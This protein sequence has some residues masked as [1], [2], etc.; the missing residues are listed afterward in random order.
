MC[1]YIHV[2]LLT[3]V[4]KWHTLVFLITYF[5]LDTPTE[6]SSIKHIMRF[7]SAEA[8]TK[9]PQQKRK[10]RALRQLGEAVGLLKEDRFE[11]A[12]QILFDLRSHS[13]FRRRG[14]IYYILG[15]TLFKM[16]LFQISAFQFSEVIRRKDP[17]YLQPSVEKLI[18]LTNEILSSSAVLN[19]AL[20]N[21]DLASFP[22]A[23]R[24]RLHLRI[25]EV[26]VNN[27]QFS[28]AIRTLRN[29]NSNSK[30][31]PHAK[32]LE[33][34]SYAE[35]NRPRR[36]LRSFSRI[37]DSRANHPVN[38]RIKA[39]GLMGMA[40]SAYQLKDWNRAI[41]LYRRIPRDTQEWFDSLF[42]LTWAQM[43]AAQFRFVLGNFHSL[44]SPYYET[45]YQPE[46]FILRSI[47]Y[48]YI[49]QYKEM[50]RT[51][52]F[53]QKVYFPVRDKIRTYMRANNNSRDIYSDFEKMYQNG[54]YLYQEPENTK[55]PYIAVKHIFTEE[56][57]SSGMSYITQVQKELQAVNSMSDA[58]QNSKMGRYAKRLLTRRLQNTK[59]VVGEQIAIHLRRIRAD[60]AKFIRQHG[61]ARYE[62][63][64][65]QKDV[66]KRRIVERDTKMQSLSQAERNRNFYVQGGFEYWP[67]QGEYWLDEVGNYYYLGTNTCAN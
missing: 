61:L 17:K 31:Y 47:V 56:D 33:G 64:N 10:S 28:E 63:L 2:D 34:L 59:K 39:M 42:E 38:D 8:Q 36:A 5:A 50:E 18:L 48:L 32:Y 49:C 20:G 15:L 21:I 24:D 52:N 13:S 25:G 27:K 6:I 51:L 37:V 22:K 23:H 35:L 1:K 16:N 44:H 67:F 55:V 58:W 57:V 9:R 11:E 60:L 53:F 30:V 3:K 43:R 46:S 14:R 4:L 41:D 29:I 26:Q 19:Y 54:D 66:L 62:M 7:S 65:A 45:N 40:R 12:S